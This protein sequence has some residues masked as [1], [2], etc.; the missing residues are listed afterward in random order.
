MDSRFPQLLTR[1]VTATERMAQMRGW[2][3][4]QK[5]CTGD[6]WHDEN[7]EP[8]IYVTN[9]HRNNHNN[10]NNTITGNNNLQIIASKLIP[11]SR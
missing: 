9:M 10:N 5:K 2:E 6:I 7:D 4:E 8:G 11:F 1:S 3:K